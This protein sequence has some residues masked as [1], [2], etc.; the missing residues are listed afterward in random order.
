MLHLCWELP[1]PATQRS[2]WRP[3]RVEPCRSCWSS[4]LRSSLSLQELR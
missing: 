3:S 4:W 1:F 2:R